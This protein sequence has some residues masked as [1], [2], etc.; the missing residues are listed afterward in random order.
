MPITDRLELP[1]KVSRPF[2]R[3][4]RLIHYVSTFLEGEGGWSMN[5]GA[6]FSSALFFK[7]QKSLLYFALSHWF[8]ED[9]LALYWQSME[10]SVPSD[11]QTLSLTT[12]GLKGTDDSPRLYGHTGEAVIYPQVPS[13]VTG[14]VRSD[15]NRMAVLCSRKRLCSRGSRIALGLSFI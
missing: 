13:I 10:R 7:V 14:D 9:C 2:P 15:K 6:G 12:L 1:A 3:T 5:C 11:P 8:G 4:K